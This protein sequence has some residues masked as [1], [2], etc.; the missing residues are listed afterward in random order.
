MKTKKHKLVVVGG[1][2][3]GIE[4]ATVLGQRSKNGCN[5]FD[6]TLVDRD[7]AHIWKPMLHT[8]AAGTRDVA[9]QQISYI[10][11]AYRCNFLY[12]PGALIDLDRE[13]KE[14]VVDAIKS[15]DGREVIPRRR[16]KYDTLVLSLG[17]QAN[18]FGTLGVKEHCY[19]IDSR[20]LAIK[21]QKELRIRI[22]Q[23]YSTKEP[24]NI[25]IVGGGATGV[26]LA[27]EICE[28]MKTTEALGLND[29]CQN[30][31]VTLVESGSRLLAN[32]PEDISE[33]TKDTLE[34][35]GIKV[36]L[37]SKVTSATKQGYSLDGDIFIPSSLKVWAAGVKADDFLS[38]LGGLET[39]RN[40]QLLVKPSLQTTL[41][42][43]IFA[44]GDCSSLILPGNERALAPTA[45]I[46]HQQAQHIIKHLS[47]LVFQ[48][49]SIPEF[50][51]HDFG[52]I[53]ALGSYDAFASLGQFGLLKQ[54]TLRGLLAQLG[55]I[56]LY[57]TH[58]VMLYGFW[59]GSLF[60]LSE[61]LLARVKPE[62]HID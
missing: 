46:A 20:Q 37:N 36:L 3:A 57:R 56:M 13:N 51:Y 8:I 21:F 22:F 16:I 50:K 15:P 28:F 12:Q 34:K 26:E 10:L 5:G 7:T 48:Q 60:W 27:V 4:I 40:N 11:Q 53:V 43:S 61:K 23:A 29:M 18:D 31:S 41:D 14:I 19:S 32:F 59:R 47:G 55:H 6:V 24:L 39:N 9:Q 30:Y 54:A 42:D 38:T 58:Q 44:V 52:S 25:S 1:G 17:S 33:A 62:I 49:K 45:Q 2:I 35:L